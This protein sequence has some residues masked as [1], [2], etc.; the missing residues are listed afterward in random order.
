[1]TRFM[2]R[3]R[4]SHQTL[5]LIGLV[6]LVYGA[7]LVMGASC[8]L[9]HA[10]QSQ[11][12]QHHHGE[13][14][15]SAQNVLCAWACQATAD[16]TVTIGPPSSVSELVVGF[17]NLVSDPQIDSTASS[18]AHSRAPPSTPFVRLG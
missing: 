16:T 8:A 4:R 15:S 3:A 2:T 1:M 17:S 6:T 10:D 13:Q 14:E 9:A 7:L 11:S 12:Q 18:T 5:C